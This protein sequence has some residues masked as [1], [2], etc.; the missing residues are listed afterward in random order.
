MHWFKRHPHYLAKESYALSNDFN[1]KER[2][3]VRDNFLVSHGNI[4]LRL[5]KIYRFPILIVYPESTPYELPLI[6]PLERELSDEQVKNIAKGSNELYA[7]LPLIV[8]YYYQFRHQNGSGNLCILEWDNL[9]DGSK[10]YG[11]TTILKRVSDWYKGIVTGDFPA[12]SQEVDFHAHFVN[13]D[14][15]YRF[16]YPDSFLNPFFTEGEAYGLQVNY[17]PKGKYNSDDQGIYFGCLI[18]GKNKSGVYS[19]IEFSLPNFFFEEGI[20]NIVELITKNEIIQR[21]ITSGK[22]LKT[23]WFQLVNEPSPFEV[24]EEL[25]TIIGDGNY[26]EGIKRIVPFYRQSFSEKPESLFIA[27]R[28]PNRKGIQEFQLF[29]V[30]KKNDFTGVILTVGPTGTSEEEAGRYFLDSYHNVE[31]IPCEMFTEDSYHQRNIGRADRSILK[32]KTINIVGVGALGSEIADCLTKAGIGTINL[33]D[34]QILKAPNP[35]RHLAGLDQA[36][37]AKVIAV[38]GIISKHNPFV[39]V[40]FNTGNINYIELNLSFSDDSITISSIADDN[41]EGYLNER[42]VINNKVIYYSRA[43]RGGK[44]ARIFRV[45]PG[46][47]ACFHCLELYRNEENRVIIVPD[48]DSL[49]TLKNECNNPIRPASAA[50]LKLIS[51]LT[52]RIILD[53]LQHGFGE[54]NHWIWSSEEIHQVS[55]FQLYSDF[56]EPHPQCYYCNHEKIVQV[57]LSNSTQ[58]EMQDLVAENP[59]I[60]TGGVLAGYINENGDIIITTASGPGPNSVRTATEFKK[61][62]KFCQEFLEEL[63]LSSDRKI[64]YVGEWH[65]HPIE[66]NK[67]SGTDIKSLTEIAIQ[68]EYLT[69]MPVMLI[70]SNTGQ[71]SCTIH[72]A[73]KHYYFA[74]LNIIGNI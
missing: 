28:F 62:I 64:I 45:I 27:V 15:N 54:K 63:F 32:S 52:S 53:E 20:Q 11:I 16:L 5:D 12:D 29:K 39:N 67:P 17:I 48:D 23:T 14:T 2:F 4:I 38:A 71:P 21:L 70:F 13:I 47:D 35:V 55:A 59:K 73:G 1:Y 49:P 18:D 6:F 25:I 31:A 58:R 46:K 3:Q 40:R 68:K 8:K 61:D 30:I 42:A 74:D 66:N 60:E 10:F 50:D 72:P 69:D 34:N 65:S 33:F 57:F 44:V 7:I 37:V 43:L 22:L 24:F 41:T 26:D 51:S 56:I 9:D 19:Q 36:G